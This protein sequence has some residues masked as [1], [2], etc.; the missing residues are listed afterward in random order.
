MP[1]IG[2]TGD[3]SCRVSFRRR[4]APRSLATGPV[5]ELTSPTEKR[6]TPKTSGQL[7]RAVALLAVMGALAT[8]AH[9]S[10][11]PIDVILTVGG[12]QTQRVV[13]W[14]TQSSAPQ[15]LVWEEGYAL[16]RKAHSLTTT[17]RPPT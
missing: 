12:D 10:S 15:Q 4:A 16:D 5:R 17:P 6:L 7:V 2:H 14:Y 13:S 1:H 3:R 8:S 9:A 11:G